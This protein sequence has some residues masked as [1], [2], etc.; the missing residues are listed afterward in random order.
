MGSSA[1]MYIFLAILY[2]VLFIVIGTFLVLRQRRNE[3]R[4]LAREGGTKDKVKAE[5]DK[6]KD[7]GAIPESEENA[8]AGEVEPEP[9]AET[10]K[11]DD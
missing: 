6:D 10:E 3:E 11:K 7:M 2:A 8:N 1:M 5:G 4:R 9:K